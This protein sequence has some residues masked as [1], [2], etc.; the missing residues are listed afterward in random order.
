[1]ILIIFLFYFLLKKLKKFLSCYLSRTNYIILFL[2][3]NYVQFNKYLLF[4]FS[5]NIYHN[6]C[7]Y[8]AFEPFR[9]KCPVIQRYVEIFYICIIHNLLFTF[10]IQLVQFNYV[11]YFVSFLL[12]YN[13]NFMQVQLTFCLLY[14]TLLIIILFGTFYSN[15]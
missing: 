8:F 3:W 1:M 14:F 4:R 11:Y 13:L 5:F 6:Y 9:C 7:N 12:L 10:L 15:L 2:C